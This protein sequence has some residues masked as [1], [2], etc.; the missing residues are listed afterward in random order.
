MFLNWKICARQFSLVSR[1]KILSLRGSI[2]KTAV[3]NKDQSKNEPQVKKNKPRC[4]EL[5][6]LQY[7]LTT[8]KLILLSDNYKTSGKHLLF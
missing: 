4:K 5:S 7:M 8:S 2:S 1:K 6:L 3:L